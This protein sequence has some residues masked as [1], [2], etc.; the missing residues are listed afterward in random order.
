MDAVSGMPGTDKEAHNNWQQ[1][2]REPKLDQR[3]VQKTLQLLLQRGCSK[4]KMGR[5]EWRS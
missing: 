2:K 1:R 3:V 4:L 5:L